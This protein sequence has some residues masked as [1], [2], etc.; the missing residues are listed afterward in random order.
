M[1]RVT[2]GATRFL[3][4]GDI[5]AEGEAATLAAGG[6]PAEVVKVPHHGSRTSSSAALA[7]AVAP[8]YAV[9][10]AGQGNRYGFPH[11]EAVA[12]WEAAGAQVART[13]QGAVR[14]LSDGRRV[15]RVP[16]APMLHPLDTLG[17]RP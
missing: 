11:P 15:R 13:D 7:A 5:E 14:F 8:A 4:T 3:F 6:L 2:Y 10:T 1:L 16:A 17:E 9:V 12:R